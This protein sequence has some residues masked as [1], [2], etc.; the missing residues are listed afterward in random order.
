MHIHENEDEI[1]HIL[2][3]EYEIQCGDETYKATTGAVAVLP[4]RI[5]H[6]SRN[7]SNQVSR[8]LL[9]CSPGGFDDFM[10]ELSQ[11]QTP[12]DRNTIYRKYGFSLM[13]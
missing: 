1:Y 7:V 6:A 5:P 10:E 12:E 13:S 3:G 4:R 8:A 2:E 9:L 11:T